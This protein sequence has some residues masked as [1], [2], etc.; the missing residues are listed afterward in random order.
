MSSTVTPP[1][2]PTHSSTTAPPSRR[3]RRTRRRV[4]VS[5][6]LV[7]VL[8]LGQF[9][10]VAVVPVV[11]VLVGTLRSARLQALRG[12]AIGLAAAYAV[13]LAIWA[14]SPD[15]AQSLSKDIHP[16]FAGLVV[17]AA[18]AVAVRGHLL[19]RG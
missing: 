2:S 13:P 9:A 10:L 12:W 4:L 8:V 6:W 7:P 18:L 15:R 3:E 19:R 17:A 1:F 16:V 5:A 11:L 14:F